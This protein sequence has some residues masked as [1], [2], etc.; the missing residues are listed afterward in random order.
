VKQELLSLALS[1]GLSILFNPISP[2]GAVQPAPIAANDNVEWSRVV[3]NPF[4]GRIVYD[5]HYRSNFVFVSSWAK[6][7]I[8]AT[9][10]Q[11]RTE[12]VGYRTYDWSRPVFRGYRKFLEPYYAT[13]PV[14]QRYFLGSTPD[15]IKFALNGQIYTYESGPISPE[16]ATALASAPSQNLTIRLVWNDGMT[17]DVE[18]GRGTVDAWKEIFK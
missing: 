15:A 13:E 2:A 8:R 14:Y 6:S 4:D 3:E 9:Y 16:L 17:K 10:T 7:G 12:L 11:V 1:L 18:I 5:R